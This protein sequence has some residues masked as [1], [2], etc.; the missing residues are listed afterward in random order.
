M[1]K[2]AFVIMP[3][4]KEFDSVYSKVITPPLVSQG[5]TVVRADSLKDRQNILKK[6]IQ[7]IQ[8]SSLIVADLTS[9]NPNV[10]YELGICHAKDKPVIL[11]TQDIS[12]VPFDLKSYVLEPYTR[13][14]DDVEKF[15]ASF[16]SL[17]EQIGRDEIVFENPVNDF[18]QS[19]LIQDEL[20]S[21]PAPDSNSIEQVEE[22][23]GVLDTRIMLDESAESIGSSFNNIKDYLNTLTE[24]IQRHSEDIDKASKSKS[25]SLMHRVVSEAAGSLSDF[26]KDLGI[27]NENLRHSTKIF[28]DSVRKLA[29]M[30]E[31]E[32]KAENATS[33]REL[34][35]IAQSSIDST[36]GFYESVRNTRSMNISKVYNKA[37]DGALKAIRDSINLMKVIKDSAETAFD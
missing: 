9:N 1:S 36:E 11:I 28:S 10:F 17:L 33:A 8:K 35:I 18:W 6:I 19:G 3:F 37:A 29:S 5:Y 7:Q 14:I 2:T 26:T 31:G 12:A 32:S 22:E 16:S 24:R 25:T 13:D 30:S 27:E 23:D 4:G 20:V 21:P 34:A 15:I